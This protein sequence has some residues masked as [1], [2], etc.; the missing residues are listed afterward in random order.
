M[1]AEDMPADEP[2]IDDDG[3]HDVC[4]F[5]LAL[6]Y[7]AGR[8][9]VYRRPSRD[10]PFDP[11]TGFRYTAAGVPVCVHPGKVGLPAARYASKRIPVPALAPRPAPPRPP[12]RHPDALAP[13]RTPS[14]RPAEPDD[15]AILAGARPQVPEELLA[16]LRGRLRQADPD[17][18]QEAVAEAEL[19]A[20][21]S[22]PVDAVVAAI[23][24]VLSGG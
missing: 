8:F 9:D 19:T 20:C 14:P 18:L 3:D 11:A 15:A 6:R 16:L 22:F 24:Q 7:P 2:F 12:L 1:P 13:R 17:R 23:R 5:C 21:H 10:A 4:W